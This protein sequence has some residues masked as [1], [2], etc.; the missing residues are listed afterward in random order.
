MLF[1]L[2]STYDFRTSSTINIVE[3]AQI[4][5]PTRATCTFEATSNNAG[6][7]TGSINFE[8]QDTTSLLISWNVCGLSAG[9]HTYHVHT[10]GDI[11]ATDG[12]S[13]AGHFIGDCTNCRPS[14]PQEVGN[15][16]AGL[17]PLV[18]DA[19]GCSTLTTPYT[20]TVAKLFGVNSIIG[21]SIIIHGNAQSSGARVAQC[22]IGLND[23]TAAAQLVDDRPAARRARCMMT[24][25]A[26]AANAVHGY[27]TFEDRGSAVETR[28]FVTGLGE[29][30]PLSYHIH[31]KGNIADTTAASL[32][33][34]HFIGNCSGACRPAGVLQEVGM[35]NDGKQIISRNNIVSG[36]FYDSVIKLSGVDSIIGRSVVIHAVL[37]DS[38]PRVA[39][40]VIGVVDEGSFVAPPYTSTGGAIP[41]AVTAA[42]MIRG[43]YPSPI[44]TGALG[45]ISGQ[46]LF[47]AVSGSDHVQVDY[48][49]KNLPPGSHTWHVHKHGGMCCE[50]G[51]CAS[52]HFVGNCVNCR[53]SGKLQEVGLVNNGTAFIA[54]SAGVARGTFVDSAIRLFGT[55]SILGRSIIVHG[56]GT[57]DDG[58]RIAQGSIG[59]AYD[60]PTLKAPDVPQV[61]AA[62]CKLQP[63]SANSNNSMAG[64]VTFYRDPS[65]GSIITKFAMS[66]VIGHNHTWHVHTYGD[67]SATEDGSATTGHFV[68]QLPLSFPRPI[69][70][71]QEVGLL[72]DGTTLRVSEFGD[73]FGAFKDK[74][75]ALNGVDSIV[76]RSIIVHGDGTLSGSGVRI[77]QCVIGIT[78][79]AAGPPPTCPLVPDTY[80]VYK[81]KTASCQLTPTPANYN[82]SLTGT[83][84]FTEDDSGNVTVRYQV[85]GLHRS[86]HTFHVHQLGNILSPTASSTGGHFIG[87]CGGFDG[88]CR[89]ANTLQ[90]VGN[91][92]AGATINGS[93]ITVHGCVY[94][95]VVDGVLSLNGRNSIIGRSVVVHGNNESS[96][97]RVAQ[98]VIGRT[99]TEST[100]RINPVVA[101][102]PLVRRASCVLTATGNAQTP[103]LSGVLTF[104]STDPNSV[105]SPVQIN[106][107]INGLRN[108]GHGFHVHVKGDISDK[109]SGSATSGHF[110][111][112][113]VNCRKSGVLQEVGMIGDGYSL[114]SRDGFAVA[115]LTDSVLRL[116]GNNSIVGRSVIVHIGSGGS[117][118]AQC[119]IGIDQERRAPNV[120]GDMD[121]NS[122]QTTHAMAL[123]EPSTSVG[124]FSSARGWVEMVLVDPALHKV[125]VNYYISGLTPNAAH[126]WD[127]HEFGNQCFRNASD[128]FL[129]SVVAGTTC[130]STCNPNAPER[131][132][133]YLGNNA[134]IIA[135]KYGVAR[136]QLTDSNIA[137]KSGNSVLGRMVTIYAGIAHSSDLVAS[138]VIGRYRED[139]VHLAYE[140]PTVKHASCR[141]AP[142]NVSANSANID[143]YISFTY[144]YLLGQMRTFYRVTGLTPGPHTWHVHDWGNML[145]IDDGSATGGHFIG[146]L[147]RARPSGIAQ[148]VGM[149]NDG[150]PMIAAASGEAFGYFADE[151]AA[152]YEWNNI[153]GRSI[154]IHGANGERQAQ[155]VIGVASEDL[156]TDRFP[157]CPFTPNDPPSAKCVLVGRNG[158]TNVSGIVSF[159]ETSQNK[160][161]VDFEIKHLPAASQL[162]FY[163]HQT[164][165]MYLQDGTSAGDVYAGDECVNCR[166]SAPSGEQ[167]VGRLT[168]N[169]VTTDSN[170]IATVSFFD[171]VVRLRGKN[172]IA[173]RAFQLHE[174]SSSSSR[175]IAECV[176]GR[177]DFG[178]VDIDEGQTP[179]RRAIVQLQDTSYTPGTGGG[180]MTIEKLADDTH[181]VR[182]FGYGLPDGLH[183]IHAHTK[184][185]ISLRDASSV[186]EHFVGSCANS[187]SPCRPYPALQE[188]GYIGD[189]YKVAADKLHAS[190]VI[191]DK[192]IKLGGAD[193]IVG[194]SIIMHGDGPFAAP[195]VMMGVI[196]IMDEGTTPAVPTDSGST[197]GDTN[198]VTRAS[199]MPRE[200]TNSLTS[201][202][203]SVELEF[204]PGTTDIQVTYMISGLTPGNHTWHVHQFG[205]LC[206]DDGSS[207]SGHFVGNCGV[208]SPCRPGAPQT[209][210]YQ[211][212]GQ[213][214]NGKPIVADA[215]GIAFGQFT[216]TVLSFGGDDAILG[217]SIIIHGNGTYPG[218][219]V[220]Q[221]VI[222]RTREEPNQRQSVMPTVNEAG[223][224]L[225]PTFVMSPPTL[226]TPVP[227]EAFV[228]FKYDSSLQTTQVSFRAERLPISS[229]LK[230]QVNTYGDMISRD[231]S[232]ATGSLFVGSGGSRPA[233]TSQAVGNIRDGIPLAVSAYGTTYGSFVD[234]SIRFNG[235]DS[236]VGRSV[237]VY[238]DSDGTNIIAQ[239]VVGVLS[240]GNDPDAAFCDLLT[241]DPDPAAAESDNTPTIVGATL[242]SIGGILFLVACF[243]CVSRQRPAGKPAGEGQSSNHASAVQPQRLN[244][245]VELEDRNTTAAE[246]TQ[247]N[248]SYGI[249]MQP[250][251]YAEPAAV[252]SAT[253]PAV[254]PAAAAAGTTSSPP[255]P[256]GWE[257]FFDDDNHPY[258]Y[259]DSTGES[260]WELPS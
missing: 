256:A 106:A 205:N 13:T 9:S 56:N 103:A 109:L 258:Y 111:G 219:R 32:T 148:E 133:G 97:V 176:I 130:D 145:R 79:E 102:P 146:Q 195:R 169:T 244:S 192:L 197:A 234:N 150:K 11:L 246:P 117:R 95:T 186:E 167:K 69:G 143:G 27:F 16:G 17:V 203:G 42:A 40:C 101:R 255:L 54:D 209:S 163:V 196:G 141:L 221:C 198:Q 116:N 201:I 78:S 254:A 224:R 135:D 105:S 242:G 180:W 136:G 155:C 238:D 68:G 10:T 88:N 113:C 127:I 38:A 182:F 73:M 6:G 215:N 188:V 47:T 23:D 241:F 26:N 247:T 162:G 233:S 30:Q 96:S 112:D 39:Q 137:L 114:E 235:Q 12:S 43:T 134:P 118:V 154:I 184:G 71:P 208:G 121:G 31:L 240:A 74:N 124:V 229:S 172:S 108:G 67:V 52:S 55:N 160:I 8:M 107:A 173:G 190:G 206:K 80:F 200:T 76:G 93:D 226:D 83:V 236:I 225:Q 75:L 51:S 144:D 120:L 252:A 7:V 36:M 214:N 151:N 191:I 187:L 64:Y 24:G 223:C 18:A 33:G 131:R 35:L 45:T 57:A 62:G 91:I 179:V 159:S 253:Q 153:V 222:G 84:T 87:D 2:H 228:H 66:A 125:Q 20:D 44:L 86:L 230:W 257:M 251:Y 37:G 139:R 3:A 178:T 77:A 126:H 217:R 210:S 50:D 189:G 199:C 82:D 49:F 152:L 92:G 98:C 207:V 174:T 171:T 245:G 1:C 72:D 19:N 243:W 22:V 122:P 250:A 239:C 248:A 185:D 138:G 4:Q 194:R 158:H 94:G 181:E 202:D 168:E 232:V 58:S 90:E 119:V 115:S 166:P 227:L 216:D 129:G 165:N 220:A 100:A 204:V 70:K 14:G 28:Y 157:T 249:Q 61:F 34:G 213:M 85:C 193:S 89:P 183:D 63:T 21:R 177:S 259:N 212:V 104:E 25:T 132:I 41:L 140:V 211:E 218:I 46:I 128:K 123:I 175:V 260:V 60:H 81:T 59:R 53:P 161:Q 164:G 65:D 147:K 170:G 237:V 110:V 29:H 149:L 99:E 15:L 142:T 48:F 156:N 5:R 231:D